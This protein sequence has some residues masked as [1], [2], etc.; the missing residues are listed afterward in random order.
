MFNSTDQKNGI[1]TGLVTKIYKDGDDTCSKKVVF[2][3]D[4]YGRAYPTSVG[5]FEFLSIP[6]EEFAQRTG[7]ARNSGIS[8]PCPSMIINKIYRFTSAV[9][10]LHPVSHPHVAAQPWHN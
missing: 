8:D 5:S 3:H 1:G 2:I 7:M 6:C 4:N 10:L 9:D